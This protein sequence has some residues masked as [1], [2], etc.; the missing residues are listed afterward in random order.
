MAGQEKYV[1]YVGTYTHGSSIGIHVYDLNIEEGVMEER[2]VIPVNNASHMTKSY[3]GKYLYS[4]ADE[5]V[6]VLRILPDGGLTP[7]NQVGID[8]MRGCYLS[9]DKSGKFLFVGGYHDGKVTVVHTHRNG[10]LGSVM[11]GIFHKGLGSVAERNFRPHVS[12]VIPTPDDKYLCAVD[13]GIDQVKLYKVNPKNGKLKLFDILRCKLESGPRLLTF[14][15]DGRFAYINCELTNEICVYTYDGSGKGP[16]FEKIQ[17]ISTLRD[18][19][20]I[21]S[22]CCGMKISPSGKYLYASTAGENT[23][24]VFQIDQDTGL[25]TRLCCLPISGEYPK[26]IDVF[27]GEKT[28]VVLNHETNEIRFFTIDYERGLLVMKG[29]PISV[30]TPNCILI[31]QV[32]ETLEP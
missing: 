17:E 13:N 18:P 22:A 15:K 3:N 5:G 2:T 28:L 8:G 4:I 12:C 1:A 20:S 31:S 29:R 26:D 6:E 9:T 7:I 30:E 19:E 14:S 24:A 21:G 23:A 32:D 25:L 16:E 27:P 11:D 10:R